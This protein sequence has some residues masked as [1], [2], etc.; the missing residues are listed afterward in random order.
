MRNVKLA[1]W[2][3][4]AVILGIELSQAQLAP[5]PLTISG[6]LVD[7][8]SYRVTKPENWNGTVV[9][10]LDGGIPPTRG[11]T[12]WMLDHGYA[13]GGTTRGACGYNFPQCVDNLVEVR[14]LFGERFGLPKRTIITGGSRGGF[15][16]R[17]ALEEELV[18]LPP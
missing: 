8:T 15:V 5:E 18:Q 1:L 11:F 2:M 9:L 12:R 14:R 13:Q 3:A 7:G 17:L 10:D 16:A 6:K 4:A